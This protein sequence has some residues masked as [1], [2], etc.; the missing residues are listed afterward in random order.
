MPCPSDSGAPSAAR[1]SSYATL[2]PH[3]RRSAG[4]Y[5]RSM[6]RSRALH[7]FFASLT[8]LFVLLLG[9]ATSAQAP[10]PPSVRADE[11]RLRVVDSLADAARPDSALTL[12][13]PLLRESRRRRDRRALA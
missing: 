10:S 5:T 7:R 8:V 6:A 11:D 9:A 1:P 12:L 3:I 2:R 4:R 13:Q